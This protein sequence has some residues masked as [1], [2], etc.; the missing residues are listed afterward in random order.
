[1]LNEYTHFE[2]GNNDKFRDTHINPCTSEYPAN[3]SLLQ[4]LSYE[5][6]KRLKKQ[7][8]KAKEIQE[9]EILEIE[10]ILNHRRMCRREQIA[11]L[12]ENFHK[13]PTVDSELLLSE[14]HSDEYSNKP[15]LSINSVSPKCDLLERTLV[16]V[17]NTPNFT[18]TRTNLF[19]TGKRY[20]ALSTDD[21]VYPLSSRSHFQKDDDGQSTI[22]EGGKP[23]RRSQSAELLEHSIFSPDHERTTS[24]QIWDSTV[25]T[26]CMVATVDGSLVFESSEQSTQSF[27]ESPHSVP[28]VTLEL[29]SF[30]M[31]SPITQKSQSLQWLRTGSP[32]VDRQAKLC[33]DSKHERAADE[34]IRVSKQPSSACLFA[35]TTVPVVLAAPVYAITASHSTHRQSDFTT[36]VTNMN[37]RTLPTS[38]IGVIC[39]QPSV[40]NHSKGSICVKEIISCV[41]HIHND[42][43][44]CLNPGQSTILT[45]EE[46]VGEIHTDG[47]SAASTSV[48]TKDIV[49]STERQSKCISEKASAIVQKTETVELC[50]IADSNTRSN[51]AD[52]H[53]NEA[54]ENMSHS[55]KRSILKSGS[56]KNSPEDAEVTLPRIESPQSREASETT[57]SRMRMNESPSMSQF[58]PNFSERYPCSTPDSGCSESP[59]SQRKSVRFADEIETVPDLNSRISSGIKIID[60]TQLTNTPSIK[61]LRPTSPN[62]PVLRKPAASVIC[63]KSGTSLIEIFLCSLFGLQVICFQPS[64]TNHSKGS[65]CVKEI[66]SCVDHIHNDATP[67]LNPGQ[68]TILTIEESV[69]EIHTDGA[70]AASTSVT[71]KDIVVSTERQSKCISEKASAIV[72]KTE[73]VELC[74]IA[75][76]NTRSN[77]ADLHT[78]E[79]DENMSHSPKRSILKS[80]SLKN[81]PEDAE[82]TLPRI[83]SPQSREA[84]E[85]THSRMRMNESPS[86]SQFCPNFSERYPC[87]TPDSGCSESPRSQR[88]SVRFADEIETVPDLNSRISSGIKII[89]FTQLTNTPSIKCLRPTSPNSP[90]LRKPAAS[91]ICSKSEIDM[92]PIRN[93]PC[94]D[95]FVGSARGPSLP[96][97]NQPVTS[98]HQNAEARTPSD[99]SGSHPTCVVQQSPNVHSKPPLQ[100]S[101]KSVSNPSRLNRIAKLGY[102]DILKGRPKPRQEADQFVFANQRSIWAPSINRQIL[103]PPLRTHE[104]SSYQV[105]PPASP[106]ASTQQPAQ[107][108]V[109]LA[110]NQCKFSSTDSRPNH[111]IERS[112]QFTR[113]L[114][115]PR[116]TARWRTHSDSGSLSSASS[117][118]CLNYSPKL[119]ETEQLANLTRLTELNYETQLIT[120]TDPKALVVRADSP[121]LLPDYEGVDRELSEKLKTRQ[122]VPAV[123]YAIYL[124]GTTDQRS[125]PSSETSTPTLHSSPELAVRT[126][127]KG[128]QSLFH[129]LNKQKHPFAGVPKATS[130]DNVPQVSSTPKY[131]TSGETLN[132]T[133]STQRIDQAGGDHEAYGYHDVPHVVHSP[134]MS[135]A[136]LLQRRPQLMDSSTQQNSSPQS[137]EVGHR[138]V[139]RSI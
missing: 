44:P 137:A 79:A 46:S 57:H 9:N 127:N 11:F 48:T 110:S 3:W 91:V 80:G 121:R 126:G 69:G 94:L 86:M 58:C 125:M 73:T 4:K 55:P 59:R 29:T 23:E 92:T 34:P 109:S 38:S 45:I 52:L 42:A 27:I 122:R 84:S 63:S 21:H 15:N 133:R 13:K 18:R 54:D 39:F 1:M 26:P 113:A 111:V 89:D 32:P 104:G 138:R 70:S 40:T 8:L 17:H 50:L 116:G 76:S 123:S 83:E 61:C 49:V 114:S 100:P 107:S 37:F 75:D 136:R 128:D 22:L 102:A 30:Q 67:C 134:A 130:M 64:V 68:S 88:K 19:E 51:S 28:S 90:V 119:A 14:K 131:F 81:S 71:T 25:S 47:A 139:R 53:T 118:V 35:T 6:N 31:T 33:S 20:Q 72:Q 87:S 135:S 74:L 43:T 132:N 60:F 117:T 112:Y 108:Y 62:S 7:A 97:P 66:I 115:E 101:V 85:T 99:G 93:S 78:N 77:S 106:P 96:V 98:Q 65:I 105:S 24:H 124:K 56:L 2:T 95:G 120:P 129:G 36:A 12:R 103:S 16:L 5:T 10:R 41:D 82:V